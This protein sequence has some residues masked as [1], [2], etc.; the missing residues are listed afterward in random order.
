[1]QIRYRASENLRE[2]KKGRLEFMQKEHK[3]GETHARGA[4][5]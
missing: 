3:I 5:F 2:K 1:M 4:F